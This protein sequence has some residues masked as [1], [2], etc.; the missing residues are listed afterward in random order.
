MTGRRE[1]FALVLIEI[2]KKKEL[3]SPRRIRRRM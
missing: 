3:F 2:K 1:D